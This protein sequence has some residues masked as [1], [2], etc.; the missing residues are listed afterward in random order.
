MT[1]QLTKHK[2]GH[3]VADVHKSDNL[4]V[5]GI[6]LAYHVPKLRTTGVTV[7]QSNSVHAIRTAER[8]VNCNTCLIFVFAVKVKFNNSRIHGTTPKR[9]SISYH[10]RIDFTT[11]KEGGITIQ[12]KIYLLI[13]I[14]AVMFVILGGV[15][16]LAQ[17]YTLNGI[18]S[19]TVG[20]G[21]HGTARFATKSEIKKTYKRVPFMPEEWRKGERLPKQCSTLPLERGFKNYYSIIRGT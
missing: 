2:L 20:D 6:F 8:R 13:L 16:L 11:C 21:Q 15:T 5:I 9:L 10:I 17:R 4:W 3:A 14:A 18:K 12:N 19:R 7:D 1:L